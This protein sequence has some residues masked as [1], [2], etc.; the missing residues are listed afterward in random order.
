ME[1]I[2][3]V[4]IEVHD[5]RHLLRWKPVPGERLSLELPNRPL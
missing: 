2:I 5:P 4:L 3:E 1:L